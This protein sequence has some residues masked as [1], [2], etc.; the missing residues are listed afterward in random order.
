MTGYSVYDGSYGG[1]EEWLLYSEKSQKHDTWLQAGKNI[2]HC[3]ISM[4]LL[5]VY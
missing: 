1:S 4:L 5:S 3:T 2:E